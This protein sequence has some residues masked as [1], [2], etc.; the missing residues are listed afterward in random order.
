LGK[1]AIIGSGFSSYILYQR[2][3]KYNPYIISPKKF[4]I[5]N[6]FF[7]RN[8]NFEINKFF[9]KKSYS[10]NN[11][12][13][14]LK[15]IKLYD[16]L[17]FGGNSNIWGGFCNISKFNKKIINFLKNSNIYIN[18]LNFNSNGCSANIP[19]IYQLNDINKNIF[20]V[21]KKF[22][23][24]INGFVINFVK[25][26]KDVELKILKFDNKNKSFFIRKTFKKVYVAVSIP[27]LINL[28]KNSEI[29]KVND[30]IT[31]SEFKS[32]FVIKFGNNF[33]RSSA[34]KQIEIYYNF[35]GVIKHFLNLKIK[36][37]LNFIPIYLVQ[38]FFYKKNTSKI[39][40]VKKNIFKEIFSKKNFGN[41]IHVDNF[42]I[43]NKKLSTLFNQ[44][45]KIF[46]P[47]AVDQ[48]IPGP[49][50]NDI[51]IDIFNRIK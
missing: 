15:N 40:N 14:Q 39:I 36:L 25:K 47:A 6:N 18:K 38:K 51:I 37:F 28:L 27:Q 23:N 50:S 43:N 19:E 30:I 2:L 21:K 22:K 29:I 11:Q 3:K 42:K 41:S 48:K 10:Y 13:F 20:S 1:I 16:R 5:N 31:F 24:F 32:N 26:K 49:I 7:L 34:N 9:S 17:I 44:N 4:L 8:K 12:I 45:I 46:G 33:K 35:F